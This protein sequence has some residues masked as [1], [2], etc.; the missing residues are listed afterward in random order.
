MQSPLGWGKLERNEALYRASYGGLLL[1]EFGK[2]GEVK[3]RNGLRRVAHR[4]Y[5]RLSIC[6]VAKAEGHEQLKR[7]PTFCHY[8]SG[9]L[10]S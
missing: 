1:Q 6:S 2:G 7:P 3:M 8:L 9:G 4:E 5:Q 10:N